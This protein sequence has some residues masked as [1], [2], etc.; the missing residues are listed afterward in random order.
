[1]GTGRL[2]PFLADAVWPGQWG[3]VNGWRAA[4]GFSVGALRFAGTV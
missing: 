1:M 2:G 3:K 4:T